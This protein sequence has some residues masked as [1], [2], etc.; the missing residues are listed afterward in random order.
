MIKSIG[1]ILLAI[2]LIM[3]GLITILALSFHGIWIVM[4]ILAI[5]AGILILLGK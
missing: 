4:G 2:W 1:F 5:A 3:W